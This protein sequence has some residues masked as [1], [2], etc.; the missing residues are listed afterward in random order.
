MCLNASVSLGI[1]PVASG[2]SVLESEVIAPGTTHQESGG[3]DDLNRHAVLRLEAV[4]GQPGWLVSV[5]MNSPSLL[6]SGTLQI[7][8]GS[9]HEMGRH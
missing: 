4:N 9:S 7:F 3:I 6:T 5:A 8:R 2:C 1:V